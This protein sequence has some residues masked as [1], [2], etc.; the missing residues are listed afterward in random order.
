MIVS[1]RSIFGISVAAIVGV[2]R[3]T[4]LSAQE[5]PLTPLIEGHLTAGSSQSYSV[6]VQAGDL[7]SGTFTMKDGALIRF[8][9]YD[10]DGKKV[11]AI[12]IDEVG[13]TPVGFVAPAAGTYRLQLTA[14]AGTPSFTFRSRT[15]SVATRMAGVR[16]EPTVRYKCARIVRLTNEL[17]SGQRDAV[18][19]FWTDAAAGAGPIVETIPDD[20]QNLL[21]TFLW[22]Q[23]YDTYNVE[24]VRAPYG[25]RDYRY[26]S[27]V[28]GTDVW[29]KTMKVHRTS[30]FLYSLSPNSRE[31]DEG[32]EQLDPLNARVWPDD[33][34][35]PAYASVLELPGAPDEL[36]IRRPPPRRGTV[37]PRTFDSPSLKARLDLFIYTPP[38]YTASGG[39]YPLV[40]F[41]DGP[42]YAT[43]GNSAPT[44]LDNLIADGRIRPPVV[45]FV[46]SGTNV[47]PNRGPNLQ[48]PAFTDAIA[49]E[50]VPW[51][52]SSYAIS[53]D[54]RDAIAG[55]FSAGA[56]ASTYMALRHPAV[57][58]NV[59]LQSGGPGG[60]IKAGYVKMPRVPV[61]FFID[62]G[63]YEAGMAGSLPFDE[64]VVAE[65]GFGVMRQ[66]RDVLLAKGYDV[67]YRETGAEHNTLHWRATLAEGLM[68]LLGDTSHG[69]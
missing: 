7:T 68:A 12:L 15:Q 35:Y 69:K 22:R 38:G 61:R 51:L 32:T 28:P 47:Q 36:W 10:L 52:R 3:A 57:F 54:P 6:R 9:V 30:R 65:L 45:C 44:S 46:S 23:T 19:Q 4:Q 33:P 64:M 56:G 20:D 40:V 66:F 62:T 27:Q 39:L 43:G 29:Y 11:K 55:G 60:A 34:Q 31:G 58:G 17:T 53:A 1:G 18:V 48:N 37:S 13:E 21:V 63:L 67:I 26:M 50:L 41:F 5:Q 16:A 49:T 42:A 2:L 59:L 8:D 24:V 25:P 14:G